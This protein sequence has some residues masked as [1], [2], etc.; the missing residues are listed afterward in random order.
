MADRLPD[1]VAARL[2]SQFDLP[3]SA[4]EKSKFSLKKH[5]ALEA[6]E[7]RAGSDLTE[8]SETVLSSNPPTLED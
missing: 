8:W 3:L 1:D 2:E 5:L 4:R 6:K 7:E